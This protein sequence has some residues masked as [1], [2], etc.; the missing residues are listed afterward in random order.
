MIIRAPAENRKIRCATVK[1]HKLSSGINA[2]YKIREPVKSPFSRA[3][4]LLCMPH[5]IH[6][7]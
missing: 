1:T 7:I 5:P 2:G 3:M 6:R 4:A